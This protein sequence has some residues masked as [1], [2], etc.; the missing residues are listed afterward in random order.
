MPLDRLSATARLGRQMRDAETSLA[1]SLIETTALLHSAAIARADIPEVSF[2]ETQEAMLRLNKMV[3]GLLSV[4]G[5]AAR[6]HGQLL[7]IHRELAG[8]ETPEKCPDY[9]LTGAEHGSQAA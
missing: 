6:A 3:A 7:D 5:D 2:A 1:S 9:F 4:Q 8:P